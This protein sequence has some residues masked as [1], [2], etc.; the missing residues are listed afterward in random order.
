MKRASD[1]AAVVRLWPSLGAMASDLQVEYDTV[2]KWKDRNNI[3]AW[4]WF[5][6]LRAA[7]RRKIN[8]DAVDLVILARDNAKQA[9]A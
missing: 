8:L 2:R 7:K 1:F 5:E 4:M 9:A 3:P 6:V